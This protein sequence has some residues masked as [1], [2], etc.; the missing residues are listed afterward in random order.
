[1]FSFDEQL[2]ELW[3]NETLEH[4][5]SADQGKLT[6]V[7]NLPWFL[8]DSQTRVIPEFTLMFT[9]NTIEISPQLAE[10]EN[11]QEGSIAVI[12]TALGKFFATV[13][14]SKK[15]PDN[16]VVVSIFELG[17]EHNM[18]AV[19]LTNASPADVTQFNQQYEQ[20]QQQAQQEKNNILARLKIQDQHIPIHLTS[21][22]FDHA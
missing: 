7:Q 13:K 9:G 3:Q 16:L 4:N 6:L 12:T 21:G 15:L 18:V 2:N 14:I 11:L 19:T 10:S 22:G 1:M 17:C 20:H 8:V 5:V